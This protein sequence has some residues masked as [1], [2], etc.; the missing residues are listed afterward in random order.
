MAKPVR[1]QKALTDQGILSRRRTEEYIREGRITVNGHKAQLGHPVYPTDVIA[2]DGVRVAPAGKKENLYIMLN[3]PRG[4]VTT[5]S[6]ELGR[7]CV[8]QLLEGLD[9]RVYP[10]GRLDKDSE[11]LLL[12]TNDGAFANLMMH[13]SHRVG[14]TYRV[15]VRPGVTEDQC[16]TL[17]AGV[18]IGEEGKPE[19]TAPASVL[20]LEKYPDRSVLQITITQGKNRQVRRMCQAVGL[21][22][23]RLKRTAVG[24]L[25][26]GMLQPG[27]WRELRKTEVAA[28]R[29]AARPSREQEPIPQDGPGEHLGSFGKEGRRAPKKS[30]PRGRGEAGEGFRRDRTGALRFGQEGKASGKGGSGKGKGPRDRKDARGAAR[31]AGA[32]KGTGPAREARKGRSPRERKG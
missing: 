12:L 25:R 14:K 29:N 2:I 4:W 13:P 30:A 15:T 5:T 17:S 9:A 3:K 24:P 19:I 26:L 10:V 23:A 11:G 16:I 20:V 28:L 8:T 6:D 22:V 32:G 1:I 7:R 31:P 27:K 18:D 21:E